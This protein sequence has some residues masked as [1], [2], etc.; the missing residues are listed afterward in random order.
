MNQ[1]EVSPV[2]YRRDQIAYF[3]ERGII[4][5]SFKALNRGGAFNRE[6]IPS[7]AIKYG[8]TQAQLMLR[9]NLMHNLVVISKTCTETR[10]KENLSLFHF[11]IDENDMQLL[12]DMTKAEDVAKREQIELKRK[13]NF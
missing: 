13:M 6:P 9:W 11:Q 12:D 7:L 4:V 8:V 1:I 10:M 2:M 5:E 3:Q